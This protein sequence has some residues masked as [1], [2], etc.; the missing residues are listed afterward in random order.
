MS[1][2]IVQVSIPDGSTAL[3]TSVSLADGSTIGGI[4]RIRLEASVDNPLWT[5]TLQIIPNFIDQVPLSVELTSVGIGIIDNLTDEQFDVI[6]KRRA[7]R[8]Y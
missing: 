5:A 2:K 6:V 4:T 1:S 3:G 7:E 8:K